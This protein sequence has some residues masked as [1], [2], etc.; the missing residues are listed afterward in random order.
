[1]YDPD[2]YTLA[3]SFLSDA[4]IEINTDANR[5]ELAQE[6]QDIIEAFILVHTSNPG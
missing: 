1:M 4:G 5:R 6:I 2:C 3:E